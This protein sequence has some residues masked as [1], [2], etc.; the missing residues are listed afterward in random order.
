[1]ERLT[2]GGRTRSYLLHL[3]P[4]PE[5]R[6]LIIALHALGGN[7][8]LMQALTSFDPLADGE[9]FIV[10]YPE[11][12]KTSSTGIRSWNARFC[13]SN[14]REEGVDDTGFLS[15]L[16]D[17]MDDRY[18]ISG[19]LVTGF[20]NGGM[21]AHLAG[22]ELSSKVTAIA[23]VA[24]TMGREIVERDARAPVPALMVHG[25]ADRIVP[26]AQHGAGELLPASE[27]V[28]Y[29]VRNNRCDP[30]PEVEE[31]ANLRTEVYRPR[32]NG[33]EVRL[34]LVKGAGHVWPGSRVHLRNEPDPRTVDVSGLICSF[35]RS[36]LR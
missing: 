23:P 26:F 15:A 36:R 20:S 13:C 9:G 22:I 27:A 24:A 31:A 34:C 33:A 29:W 5:G 32:G 25:D 19:V 3:P 7:P 2:V 21:L 30:V 28:G 14:A 1:V 6:P 17:E 11:G 35:L 10:A 18:R 16:I 8:L 12:T 4:E